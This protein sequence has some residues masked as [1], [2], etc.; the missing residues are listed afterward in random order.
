MKLE[1]EYKQDEGKVKVKWGQGGAGMKN[2]A[3]TQLRDWVRT[4]G[5]QTTAQR[6]VSYIYIYIYVCVSSPAK[7]S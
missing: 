6:Y 5:L 7:Q 3:C 1:L 4:K 2:S